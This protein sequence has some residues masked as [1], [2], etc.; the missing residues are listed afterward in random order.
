MVQ[1]SG[2]G[3]YNVKESGLEFQHNPQQQQQQ[4]DVP[5]SP[6]EF[7]DQFRYVVNVAIIA[8]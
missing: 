8:E 1:P 2:G 7:L 5:V 4:Q 3:I 6:R